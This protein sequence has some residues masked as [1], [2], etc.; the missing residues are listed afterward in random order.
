MRRV[1]ENPPYAICM[2]S[3]CSVFEV[4]CD[5]RY[6][7][8]KFLFKNSAL[9]FTIEF[10]LLSIISVILAGPKGV[11][12]SIGCALVYFLMKFFVALFRDHF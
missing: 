6:I 7:A 5:L 10:A 12:Y 9:R 3:K 1:R 4:A 2:L 8:M 11:L